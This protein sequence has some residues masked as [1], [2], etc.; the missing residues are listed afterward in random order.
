MGGKHSKEWLYSAVEA[1]NIEQIATILKVNPSYINEPMTTDCR[2]TPLSRSVWRGSAKVVTFLLDE[3]ADVNQSGP[4]MM[5]PIMWACIRGHFELVKLLTSRGARCDV[6]SEE[7]LTP[8]DYAIL[9]Q[10]YE[11]ALY[12]IKESLGITRKGEFYKFYVEGKN[13]PFCNYEE[14]V[15]HLDLKVPF[16]QCPKF[17]IKPPQPE[18]APLADPVIDPRETWTDFFKRVSNFDP[19]PLVERASLPNELQPQNRVLGKIRELINFK[20]PNKPSDGDK[21]APNRAASSI[22]PGQ[23][24][25][26]SDVNENLNSSAINKSPEKSSR[27]VQGD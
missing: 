26:D 17:N 21:S 25:R 14:M 6:E 20:N 10:N 27:S 7:G 1:E 5:T 16:E 13:Y 23:K 4:K 15:E 2:T 24:E 3:G 9:N 8:V 12:M 22:V 11:I 18:E 19:P